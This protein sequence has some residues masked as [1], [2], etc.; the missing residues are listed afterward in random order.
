[1]KLFLPN[2]I[3]QHQYLLLSFTLSDLYFLISYSG[4][5]MLACLTM[6]FALISILIKRSLWKVTKLAVY[7]NS[8]FM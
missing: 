8:S 1:M 2:T 5:F 6:S 3:L 7:K 4:Y